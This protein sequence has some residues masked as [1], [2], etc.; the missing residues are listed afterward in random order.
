MGRRQNCAWPFGYSMNLKSFCL[1]QCIWHPSRVTYPWCIANWPLKSFY[2]VTVPKKTQIFEKKVWY[3]SVFYGV[4]WPY[5]MISVAPIDNTSL[6]CD[7]KWVSYAL[8]QA[9]RIISHACHCILLIFNTFFLEGFRNLVMYMNFNKL[10]LSNGFC[11]GLNWTIIFWLKVWILI[12]LTVAFPKF[13]NSWKQIAIL[14]YWGIKL[15]W[16]LLMF[17]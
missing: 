8:E 14:Q 10:S 12:T 2:M 7:P 17:F 9:E 6:V 11:V 13:K 5:T 15:T 4:L 3:S 1:F 16:V